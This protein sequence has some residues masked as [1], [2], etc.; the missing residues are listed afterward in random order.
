MKEGI[1]EH[2]VAENPLDASDG[3]SSWHKIQDWC[4]IWLSRM[5]VGLKWCMAYLVNGGHSNI[6]VERSRELKGL[7]ARVL[8]LQRLL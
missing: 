3:L 8:C 2:W 1:N 6:C 4:C 7:V 5:H